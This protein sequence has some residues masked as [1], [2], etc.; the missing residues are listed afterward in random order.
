MQI[1]P[2]LLAYRFTHRA[3]STGERHVLPTIVAF[4]MPFEY[5]VQRVKDVLKANIG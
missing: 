2:L 4:E 3:F 1:M 5:F